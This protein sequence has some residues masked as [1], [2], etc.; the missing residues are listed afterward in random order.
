MELWKRHD[1]NKLTG[2]VDAEERNGMQTYLA[3]PLKGLVVGV[4]VARRIRTSRDLVM[5]C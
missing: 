1:V 5:C 3:I 4:V 2:T